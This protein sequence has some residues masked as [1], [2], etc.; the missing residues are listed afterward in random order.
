MHKSKYKIPALILAG[1]AISLTISIFKSKNSSSNTERPEASSSQ[2]NI[3]EQELQYLND[4]EEIAWYEVDGNDI[5]I[6]FNRRPN[7]ISFIL[8]GAALRANKVTNF[9]VHVWGVNA[10]QK[11][12][13]PGDGPYYEEVTA[14]Y[15]EI[16]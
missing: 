6:G 12:W 10:N 3:I 14:R 5:Y 13:R 11:G 1:L 7:D 16:E 2:L 4:I 9:G 8:R 15:G